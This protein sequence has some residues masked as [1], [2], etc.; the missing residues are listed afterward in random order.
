VPI[1]DYLCSNCRER[2]EVIHGISDPGPRFCPA[3]GAEGTLRKAF[4]LPAVHFKGSGWAKKDRSSSSSKARARS[5]SGSDSG[6]K[7]NA[8]GEAPSP[9]DSAASKSNGSGSSSGSGSGTGSGGDSSPTSS[10]SAAG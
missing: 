7:P 6:A 2:T 1:Y 10:D 4:A 9:S 5:D 3:C 8:S